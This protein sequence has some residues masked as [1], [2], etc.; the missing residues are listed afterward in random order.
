MELFYICA[1][2]VAGV[3]VGGLLNEVI[4][5]VPRRERPFPHRC[6]SCDTAYRP[7]EFLM[8][9]AGISGTTKCAVCGAERDR[10]EATVELANGVLWLFCF[11]T[12]RDSSPA[13]IILSMMV[14]SVYLS[15][16]FIDYDT[17]RIPEY[18]FLILIGLGAL[19]IFCNS[20]LELKERLVGVLFG[21]G[22]FTI[23]YAICFILLKK[24]GLGWGDIKLMSVSGFLM[25]WRAAFMAIL[26]AALTAVLML[27]VVALRKGD[28]DRDYPFAAFIAM[29][30]ITAMMAGEPMLR[31]YIRLFS[32]L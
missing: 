24:E 2:L 28:R 16:A 25:G 20:A 14:V 22:F 30:S 12:M 26:F 15:L 1:V 9:A 19:D 3:L 27:L 10:R 31:T 7:K 11:V 29:G 32:L 6:Q 13:H 4:C 8:L 17:M 23:C 5:R 18:F 21:G